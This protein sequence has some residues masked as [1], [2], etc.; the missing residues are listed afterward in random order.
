ML[1]RRRGP[2]GQHSRVLAI[3]LLG[4]QFVWVTPEKFE[5]DKSEELIG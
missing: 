5:T 4:F 2:R 3:I 1:R